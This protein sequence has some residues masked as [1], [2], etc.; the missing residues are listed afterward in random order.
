MLACG[1]PDTPTVA[2]VAAQANREDVTFPT[3]FPN[4]IPHVANNVSWYWNTTQ[5]F[6]FAPQG[7]LIT[8]D[9][10]DVVD[11]D[12]RICIHFTSDV[13]TEGYRCGLYKQETAV[14][15]FRMFLHTDDESN[16]F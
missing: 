5:S 7:E 8:L 14:G 9:A 1:G 12:N 4:V 16:D 15:W 10:C 3:Q 13:I 6:G 2:H 11:E